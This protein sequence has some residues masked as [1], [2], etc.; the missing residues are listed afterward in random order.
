MIAIIVPE[1]R[2]RS[3]AWW[4]VPL[5]PYMLEQTEYPLYKN[6]LPHRTVCKMLK[7]M[8]SVRNPLQIPSGS[9]VTLVSGINFIIPQDT[10]RF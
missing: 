7:Y 3:I 4:V 6:N 9:V 8:A 2:C 5:D 10:L 1:M